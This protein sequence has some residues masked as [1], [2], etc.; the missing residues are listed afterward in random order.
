[1]RVFVISAY[2]AVRAGLAALV[3]DQPGWLVAGESDPAALARAPATV[4]GVPAED[5]TLD[6]VLADVDAGTS[7]SVV[8]AWLEMLQPRAGI[9]VLGMEPAPARGQMH[10]DGTQLVALLARA[11]GQAGLAY[12]ALRRDAATEEIIATLHAVNGGVVALDRRL[13]RE[14]FGSAQRLLAPQDGPLASVEEPLTARELEVLQLLAQG[15]PNKL[16]AQRLRISEHTAK[17]HVSAIL[18]K[19]GAGSRTEAVTSAARR[20]LLLL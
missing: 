1:M 17:F 18:L 7:S 12:G 11:A 4:S 8:T 3:R 19:L 13:A 6:I 20:G 10:S 5:G 2:P 16:I 9:V 14:T 15:L